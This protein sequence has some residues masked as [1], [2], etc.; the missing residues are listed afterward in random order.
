MKQNPVKHKV[1]ERART[2]LAQ[3]LFTEISD[4]RLSLVTVVAVEV[5]RDRSI[6]D[7]YIATDPERYDEVAGGL[8]SARG[9]LR[10]LLGKELGWRLTPELRFHID[11]SLDHAIRIAEALKNVPQTLLSALGNV[12]DG[13]FALGNVDDGLSASGNVDDGLFASGNAADSFASGNVDDGL[14]ALGNAADL[15]A[16]TRA[17][18]SFDETRAADDRVISKED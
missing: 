2:A 12:D 17:V 13:L 3:L 5:T 7:V 1:N 4:P 11:T 9:C 18:D 15:S 8:E 16:E 14:F 6:A 10:S